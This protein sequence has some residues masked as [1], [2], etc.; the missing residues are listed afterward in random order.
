M[1][2]TSSQ[3]RH[4]YDWFGRAQDLQGFYEDRATG[5]LLARGRFDD[6]RA[7]FEFGC[8]TGRSSNPG[9]LPGRLQRQF[10]EQARSEG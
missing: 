4:F 6:A 1:G 3:A 9:H 2:L 10:L 8:G 7:V 5:D